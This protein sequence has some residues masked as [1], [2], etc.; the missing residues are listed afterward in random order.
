MARIAA[1]V[2]RPQAVRTLFALAFV[3]IGWGG[4]YPALGVVANTL[5]PIQ[6]AAI[7]FVVAGLIAVGIVLLISGVPRLSSREWRST[8][9]VGVI[10]VALGQGALMMSVLYISPG[11]VALIFACTPAIALILEASFRKRK[12]NAKSILSISLGMFGV[13]WLLTSGDVQIEPIG[14]LLA[15][16]AALAYAVGAVFIDVSLSAVSSLAQTAIQ[17][18]IGGVLLA[19]ASV[20]VVP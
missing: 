6:A 5:Q 20:L 13:V 14:V 17:M 3:W 12:L 8:I 9:L 18:T 15:F 4:S 11:I 10:V 2:H 16:T 7:R 19:A 1:H